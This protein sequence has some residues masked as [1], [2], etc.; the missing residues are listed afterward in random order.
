MIVA[1]PTTRVC[2]QF[3]CRDI[4]QLAIG[5][6]RLRPKIGLHVVQAVHVRSEVRGDADRRRKDPRLSWSWLPVVL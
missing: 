6:G 3:G 1:S 5:V 2:C 4:L